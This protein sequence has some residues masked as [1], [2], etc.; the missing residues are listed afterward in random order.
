MP[1][2]RIALIGFE[3]DGSCAIAALRVVAVAAFF[4]LLPSGLLL[5][6]VLLNSYLQK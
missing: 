2:L 3:F 4:I 5:V 6:C 1:A